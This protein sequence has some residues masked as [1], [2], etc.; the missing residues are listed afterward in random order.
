MASGDN[1]VQGESDFQ[2]ILDFVRLRG[3]VQNALSASRPSCLSS[4]AGDFSGEEFNFCSQ[5]F[6]N[7]PRLVYNYT[8]YSPEKSNLANPPD[9]TRLLSLFRKVVPVLIYLGTSAT[10]RINAYTSVTN[11]KYGEVSPS[12][13]VKSSVT[14][15]E[16]MGEFTQNSYFSYW[17]SLHPNVRR[18]ILDVIF[19]LSPILGAGNCVRQ[20]GS[21]SCN[22]NRARALLRTVSVLRQ[23]VDGS[24]VNEIVKSLRPDTN[25]ARPGRLVARSRSRGISR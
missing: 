13:R 3:I 21:A 19:A 23:T 8:S 4:G 5:D 9:E 17:F 2:R 15:P 14:V 10:R 25:T 16:S 24:S 18:Q 22:S 7:G 12:L 6:Y 1:R 20:P 11:G